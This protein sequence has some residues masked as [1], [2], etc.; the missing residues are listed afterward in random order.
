MSTTSTNGRVQR[1][2]LAGQLDRLDSILDGLAN[3]LNE[4][5]AAAVQEAVSVAVAAALKEVL[6][7][8]DLQKRLHPSPAKT[9]NSTL[10]KLWGGL[11]GAVK[12][13]WNW[14]ANVT[15]WGRD[16]VG[17]VVEGIGQGERIKTRDFS[18][19]FLPIPSM[20]AFPLWILATVSGIII[21]ET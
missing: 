5:V 6:T 4:A 7:N 3:R 10:K 1:K 21:I 16:K 12:G 11:V 9:G 15:S 17:E 18:G 20:T 2:S 8:A 13:C 14:L 19:I